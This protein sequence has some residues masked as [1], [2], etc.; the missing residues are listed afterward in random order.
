MMTYFEPIIGPGARIVL[1]KHVSEVT[2][3]LDRPDLEVTR[4]GLW[5]DEADTDGL[6]R[7][8]AQLSPD[9]LLLVPT[10]ATPPAALARL[11]RNAGV[12]V[13]IAC[14]H[15]LAQVDQDYDMRALCRHSVNV[16]ATMLGAMMRREPGPPPILVSGFLDDMKFHDSLICAI[17]TAAL[18]RR[19]DGL[20]VGRVGPV[21]PGYD[22]LGLSYAEGETSGLEIVDVPLE[23]WAARVAGIPAAAVRDF[24]GGQLTG[25]LPPQTRIEATEG[26]VRAARMALALD[27]LADDL[28]LDCGSL[29]CRGP[30]GVG[31]EGGA[32]GCLA[33]SLMT[34]SGRPFSATGDLV[35]AVA[36]LIGK[37]LG[38]ATLY[39]E[40]DAV[41]RPSG[42]FLVANTGEADFDWAPPNGEVVIRDAGELSGRQVP[43]VVLSHQL[44][45]GPATMLGLTLDRTT[46]DRLK[47][48]AMEGRTVD[49]P[50][51][52]LKVPH[53]WF[54]SSSGEPIEA[55]EAWANAGA[56]HHGALSRGHLVQS[57]QWLAAQR[58]WPVTTVQKGSSDGR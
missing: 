50:P 54:A 5:S 42:A 12:P 49:L 7:A 18:A 15:D 14:G 10:M 46:S 11:A 26:L 17:R 45:S 29:A 13:V 35:T 3:G 31:L 51:T 19:L 41:D 36:M 33:T 39:C 20:R 25:I 53:G 4:L 23:D 1:T 8:V 32:I 24:V 58:G 9:V 38:G 44:A 30:F 34:G 52:S 37:T 22:H 56:T 43:G 47:L 16:G 2:A 57:T 55:F 28:A 48:I 21:M 6:A 40:L 27:A